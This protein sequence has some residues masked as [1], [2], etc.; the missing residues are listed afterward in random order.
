[1]LPPLRAGEGNSM[2]RAYRPGPKKSR[3]LGVAG[4]MSAIFTPG[5][6]VWP[7]S[8]DLKNH[9]ENWTGA[10]PV[11]LGS[12]TLIRSAVTYSVPVTLSTMGVAPMYCCVEQLFAGAVNLSA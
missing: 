4:V 8:V 7:P 2:V 9:S 10:V 3:P 11:Q 6:N 5:A 1:M 12:S